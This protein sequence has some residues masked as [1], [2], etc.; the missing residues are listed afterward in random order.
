VH[1]VDSRERT[2]IDE[3]RVPKVHDGRQEKALRWGFW[4]VFLLATLCAFAWKMLGAST[5]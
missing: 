2:M 3:T 4:I 1:S 5:S